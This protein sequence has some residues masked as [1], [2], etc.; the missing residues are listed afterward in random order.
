MM[1]TLTP[2]LRSAALAGAAFLVCAPA[3]AS[4]LDTDFYCRVYGCVVAHDGFSFEVYDVF[5]FAAGRPVAPGSKLVRWR[6]NVIPGSGAVTP[7]ITGTRTEG[8]QSAPL[9]DETALMGI[10]RNGDGTIDL[11]PGGGASQGYIDASDALNPFSLS[12]ASDLV[13]SDTSAQ[14]SFY[15][16]GRTP[17]TLAA[18]VLATSATGEFTPQRYANITFRY[19]VTPTG[20]DDGMEFGSH[21]KRGNGLYRALGNVNDLGDFTASFVPIMDFRQDIRQ[22]DSASLPAQSV[23]FDYVYGFRNY[24]LSMGA[25]LLSYRIEFDF[26][27]N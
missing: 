20:T 1:R 8:P 3:Q 17:F 9:R 21:A 5:D 26:Y 19:Q 22:R 12:A 7:V 10:D 2:A 4:W 25:G 14:R 24:D 13:S 23:R 15:L 11:Q 16:S 27:R 18:R 6:S